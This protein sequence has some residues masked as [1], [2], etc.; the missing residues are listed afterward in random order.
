MAAVLLMPGAC[1]LN[2][3]G[4]F[5]RP[6]I[7]QGISSACGVFVNGFEV[8]SG[9]ARQLAL[10]VLT[11]CLIYCVFSGAELA[12]HCGSGQLHVD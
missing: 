3:N 7:V 2:N 9:V 4:P 10:K 12:A 5:F 11:K 6:R 1:L 8:V